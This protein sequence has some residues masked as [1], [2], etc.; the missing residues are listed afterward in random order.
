MTKLSKAAME[1]VRRIAERNN[2]PEQEVV[3]AY[4]EAVRRFSAKNKP[5]IFLPK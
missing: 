1:A 3:D 5:I 2:I 4:A